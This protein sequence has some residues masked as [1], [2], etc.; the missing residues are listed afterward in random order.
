MTQMESEKATTEASPAA[1]PAAGS[2]GLPE[3]LRFLEGERRRSQR[4]AFAAALFGVAIGALAMAAWWT[5][6]GPGAGADGAAEAIAERL[7]GLETSSG[8][9]AAQVR[10][11]ASRPQGGEPV[12][13][14]AAAR[15]ER[16]DAS[17]AGKPST[18]SLDGGEKTRQG[19]DDA[20]ARALAHARQIAIDAGPPKA[21][22]EPIAADVKSAAPD[23]KS[24]TSPEPAADVKS[25]E[26]SDA[27]TDP[28]A[29]AK[30]KA[31][32]TAAVMEDFNTL[33]VDCG[34]EQW[35]LMAA[36][37]AG[38]DHSLHHVVLAHRSPNG[39]ATGSLTG[40]RLALERDAGTGV[41]AFVLTGARRNEA[42]VEEAFPNATTR[43]EIPGL[44]P[45][46][47]VPARLGEL[48]GTAQNG[49]IGTT[50]R[51]DMNDPNQVVRAINRVLALEKGTAMRVR[52]ISRFND[53]KLLNAIIDLAV[54]DRGEPQQTV[55]ADKAWF[56][57]DA[58]RD[59]VELC[60][61]GGDMVVAGT[62]RPLFRGHLRW[63]IHSVTPPQWRGMPSLKLV[64][65]S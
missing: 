2:S 17:I 42:G 55:F 7:H 57:L 46:E 19:S 62:R 32:A 63:P 56:E 45:L 36:E 48:F 4:A 52:G 13:E 21:P 51:V 54:D 12:V 15:P 24:T 22:S 37:V 11:L 65:G 14:T 16:G 38:E 3:I 47:L 6:A 31:A 5:R 60:C 34:L 25:A 26:A 18:D 41:A 30:A 23:V 40:E 8:T 49:A 20:I 58:K 50:A 29:E 59:Y 33:L 53:D 9:L 27:K 39:A 64:S 44:L 28:E 43:I 61:D 35:R 1:N 10:A